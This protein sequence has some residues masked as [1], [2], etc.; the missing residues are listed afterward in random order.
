MCLTAS[1]QGYTSASLL[2]PTAVTT[3][4]STLYW[5]Q[6]SPDNP[7]VVQCYS[8]APPR[9][10]EFEESGSSISALALSTNCSHPLSLASADRSTLTVWRVPL[11]D[12]SSAS[13]QL[14]C[15]LDCCSGEVV[16]QLQFNSNSN[17]LIACS[18][19]KL[20]LLKL[21]LRLELC[22]I[23]E[24]HSLP[25]T[26]VS[27][28]SLNHETV[29]TCSQDRT[30]RVWDT[31]N[32]RSLYESSILS[33]S[34]LICAQV[35][36]SQDVFM[37]GA[38]DGSIWVYEWFSETSKCFLTYEFDMK[39]HFTFSHSS[40]KIASQL[41][42]RQLSSPLTNIQTLS[43]P[44]PTQE[45]HAPHQ[46]WNLT[47]VYFCSLTL[48][49]SDPPPPSYT[50]PVLSNPAYLLI[51]TESS[52]LIINSNTGDI[53][54]SVNLFESLGNQITAHTQSITH[55]QFTGSPLSPRECYLLAVLSPHDITLMIR[56]RIPELRT[57]WKVE[58]SL[59]F[60]ATSPLLKP[61]P[62]SIRLSARSPSK[63]P[64]SFS[65][66]SS[67]STRTSKSKP[68]SLDKPIVFHARIK[69]SGYGQTPKNKMF[70]PRTAT[71]AT[72]KS[73]SSRSQP[74]LRRDYFVSDRFPSREVSKLRV[75]KENGGVRS[76][77]C[78]SDGEVLA[79][80]LTDSTVLLL[81]VSKGCKNLLSSTAVEKSRVL[82]GH[83][84][85][86]ES[87]GWSHSGRHLISASNAECLLWDVRGLRSLLSIGNSTALDI[88]HIQFFYLDKFLL[89]TSGPDL[90][91]Y[92]YAIQNDLSSSDDIKRY[93]NLNTWKL[94]LRATQSVH[95]ITACSAANAFYSHIALLALS[96]RSIAVHDLNADKQAASIQLERTV[97]RIH[98]YEGSK[99]CGVHPD[100]F[101]LFLTSAIQEGIRAWDLRTNQCIVKYSLHK[102]S[103]MPVD[104]RV[105][106]CGRF[107]ATGSEDKC[108]YVYD[109]RGSTRVFV[110]KIV[111]FSDVT[112]RLMFRPSLPEL[113]VS[114]LDG[115]LHSFQ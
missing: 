98:Q 100:S 44:N 10:F 52:L 21:S 77:S 84:A 97:A 20:L 61:S 65:K 66:P 19:N 34:P 46:N 33:S 28:F 81:S 87:I 86:V 88:S 11:T 36:P 94:A 90:C 9:T 80:G 8:L 14:T 42:K 76:L 39:I 6:L 43:E 103:V 24:G 45:V 7:R 35:H 15:Q 22:A 106:P 3:H 96:N 49:P 95:S 104:C 54:H 23:F 85:K 68:P 93:L 57:G 71:A 83:T 4:N 16:T 41:S 26:S 1:W 82:R 89:L 110:E 113:L 67:P 79:A 18:G 12:G 105:S 75:T 112:T 53:E 69:S 114:T 107:V 56:F 48:N 5:S 2:Q 60:Q 40:P 115:H 99:Y 17:F 25:I 29:I 102:N 64:I 91:L 63:E 101:N 109:L 27:F 30:F 108:V 38:A 31:S 32:H 111:G 47:G 73:N 62:L 92:A 51:T 55:T 59:N 74:C 70:V 58:R 78:S 50:S 37:L 72:V 13:Q